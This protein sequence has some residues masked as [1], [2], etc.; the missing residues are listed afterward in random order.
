MKSNK[1]IINAQIINEGEIKKGSI[2]IEGEYIQDI[3]QEE[4]PNFAVSEDTT[5]IDAENGFL[6]PGVIDDQVHFRQ[7]GLTHKAD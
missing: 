7:P 4:R 2:L 6:M 3:F 1:L 5:V